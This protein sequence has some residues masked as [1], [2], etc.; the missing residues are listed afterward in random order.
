[1]YLYETVPPAL[2]TLVIEIVMDGGDWILCFPNF[3]FINLDHRVKNQTNPAIDGDIRENLWF[4]PE[5][6]I[7]II[8]VMLIHVVR[9]VELAIGREIVNFFI[10]IFIIAKVYQISLVTLR[11]SYFL[12]FLPVKEWPGI[13]KLGLPRFWK[14]FARFLQ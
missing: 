9:N 6:F 5:T 12:Y 2:F 7:F 4:Q 3:V 10:S 11:K 1:M 8:I 14:F 13:F